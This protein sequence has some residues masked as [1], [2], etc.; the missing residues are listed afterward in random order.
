M[1]TLNENPVLRFIP[2]SEP[3][4]NRGDVL[5]QQLSQDAYAILR[6]MKALD[7]DT[8]DYVLVDVFVSLLDND[9]H[10]V[11]LALDDSIKLGLVMVTRDKDA[12]AMTKAGARYRT[13]A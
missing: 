4:W 3:L 9:E 6:R 7:A 5:M 10:R 11:S 8:G 12:L 2:E 13:H 1:C